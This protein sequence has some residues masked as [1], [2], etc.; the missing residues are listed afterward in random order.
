MTGTNCP[1]TEQ[2]NLHRLENIFASDLSRLASKAMVR[3]ENRPGELAS[4][5]N[6]LAHNF[7]ISSS[8]MRRHLSK[9]LA[10]QSSSTF[11]GL[12]LASSCGIAL[13]VMDSMLFCFLASS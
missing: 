13:A 4:P 5:D 9:K 2:V 7:C 11:S 1:P 10:I 3:L 8:E 12:A 6:T